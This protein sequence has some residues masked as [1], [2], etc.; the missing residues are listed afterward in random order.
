MISS[1]CPQNVKNFPMDTQSCSLKFGSWALDGGALKVTPRDNTPADF[2]REHMKRNDE[3]A[4]MDFY[5]TGH[6]A[7]YGCCVHPFYDVT[8]TVVMSRNWRMIFLYLYIPNIFVNILTVIQFLL[9]CDSSERCT[10][11]KTICN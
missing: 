1:A 2:N 9:P 10:L 4:V 7:Y 11:G 5:A 8:F 3:W 6:S